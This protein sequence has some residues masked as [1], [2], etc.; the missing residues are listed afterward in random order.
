MSENSFNTDKS[1]YERDEEKRWAE[2]EDKTLVSNLVSASERMKVAELQELAYS[3][4]KMRGIRE[5]LS[6]LVKLTKYNG[7]V[8]RKAQVI[9]ELK[10][11]LSWSERD[12]EQ[13]VE[14]I[15]QEGN[16]VYERLF[17]QR[18]PIAQIQEQI[19]NALL[20]KNPTPN[21]IRSVLQDLASTLRW[22][23]ISEEAIKTLLKLGARI[24]HMETRESLAELERVFNEEAL[25]P[26]GPETVIASIKKITGLQKETRKKIHSTTEE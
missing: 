17:R 9:S 3:P 11:L 7:S 26:P 5:K 22:G 4:E 23:I 1:A 13:V 6:V 15:V 14:R 24:R 8:R 25:L 19:L 2:Y 16:S 10:E 20:L 18:M 21:S 12:I